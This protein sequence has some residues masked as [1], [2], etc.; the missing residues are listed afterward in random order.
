MHIISWV[1][2]R[3]AESG[4]SA[5]ENN[6][7]GTFRSQ[8]AIDGDRLLGSRVCWRKRWARDVWSLGE[9]GMAAGVE[10]GGI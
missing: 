9:G 3:T 7:R 1:S 8:L 5:K 2:P 10:I 6:G 4:A